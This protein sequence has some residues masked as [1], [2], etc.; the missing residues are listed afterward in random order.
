VQAFTNAIT[1]TDKGN[2]TNW[3]PTGWGPTVD[4]I[5]VQG[6]DKLTIKGLLDVGHA[7]GAGVCIINNISNGKEIKWQKNKGSVGNRM[8]GNDDVK[9]KEEEHMDFRRIDPVWSPSAKR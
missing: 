9:I 5:I 3:N 4:A 6:N 2:K 8:G 7:E 1:T